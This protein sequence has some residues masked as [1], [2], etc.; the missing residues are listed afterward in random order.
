MR[1]TSV[2]LAQLCTPVQ[3]CPLA[4]GTG[5]RSPDWHGDGGRSHVQSSHDG[6]N[7]HSR[8]LRCSE[9]REHS[10]PGAFRQRVP[11]RHWQT[12]RPSGHA[13][14]PG[15]RQSMAWQKHVE[16]LAGK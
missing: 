3:I 4:N 9:P 11:N 6:V 2:S 13:L 14:D 8:R 15:L 5:S 7:H 12:P 10:L 16:Q 1:S